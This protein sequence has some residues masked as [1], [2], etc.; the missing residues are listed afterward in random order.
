M[1]TYRTDRMFCSVVA[2]GAALS[3]FAMAGGG[4]ARADEHHHHHHHHDAAAKAPAATAPAGIASGVWKL[5]PVGD[6]ASLTGS[7]RVVHHGDLVCA[8]LHHEGAQPDLPGWISARLDGTQGRGGW[9]D[10]EH[11]GLVTL[12][13]D[14]AA[15]AADAAA[16]AG[17][18]TRGG[19]ITGTAWD[20]FAETDQR[21]S[22]KATFAQP[23]P[24]GPRGKVSGVH[25]VAIDGRR[26]NVTLREHHDATVTGS[27]RDAASR[28]DCGA[29][30]ATRVGDAVAGEWKQV[31]DGKPRTIWFQ[32]QYK[33]TTGG[34]FV[35]GTWGQ[36][37]DGVD[38]CHNGGAIRG[39]FAGK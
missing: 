1:T 7:L 37:A 21:T 8:V 27:A 35:D 28:K 34:W 36:S 23:L 13:Y 30:K 15:G 2:A 39:G 26:C 12:S 32:W 17:S 5:E 29:I 9:A 19:A 22:F 4:V 10:G 14:A 16:P 11:K 3:A 33:P 38:S 25:V 31:V 6:G 20:G 24:T 18:V